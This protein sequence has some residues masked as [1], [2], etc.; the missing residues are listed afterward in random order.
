MRK[1]SEKGRKEEM[2]QEEKRKQEKQVGMGH[3]LIG[4]VM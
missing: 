2:E 4:D 1:I 3:T